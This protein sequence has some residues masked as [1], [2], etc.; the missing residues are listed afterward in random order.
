M[1]DAVAA[2]FDILTPLTPDERRKVVRAALTLLDDDASP[3]ALAP[4]AERLTGGDDDLPAGASAWVKKYGVDVERLH[5]LFHFDHGRVT[6]IELPRAGRTK[7]EDVLNTYLLQGVAALLGS[8]EA[9]FSDDDARRLCEHF[10]C[11][12]SSNH[13]KALGD[14]G[15]NVAGSKSAG[16]KLTAPGLATAATLVKS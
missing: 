14:F 4:N 10:G 2:V 6:C 1:T 16:W 3:A 9:N 8:G 11:Y 7:R 5:K 13:A 15:S 12:D